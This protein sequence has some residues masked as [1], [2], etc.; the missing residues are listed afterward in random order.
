L[1]CGRDEPASFGIVDP[2]IT[3]E[4]SGNWDLLNKV[5][6]RFDDFVRR[7]PKLAAQEYV[8]SIHDWIS[9]GKAFTGHT[10]FLQ[11]SIGWRPES[12]AA[13]VYANAAYAEYVEQGTGPFRGRSKWPITPKNRKALKIPNKTGGF[14]FAKSVTHT[15]SRPFPFFFADFDHRVELITESLMNEFAEALFK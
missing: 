2:V 3:I 13:V 6:G 8:G 9:A 5:P 1:G 12:N 15:G 10:G 4:L 11:Q 14:Y 7:A